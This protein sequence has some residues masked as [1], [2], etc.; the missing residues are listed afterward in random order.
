MII[1]SQGAQGA[2]DHEDAGGVP[3]DEEKDEDRENLD[4]SD[5]DP[6]D[7]TMIFRKDEDH[8]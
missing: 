6:M 8:K 4:E 5:E 1:S 2:I 7:M 3:G